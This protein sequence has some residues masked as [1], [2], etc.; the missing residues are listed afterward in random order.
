MTTINTALT[1]L[2]GID[3][4]LIL[5]PMGGASGGRLA[6][7]VS[8]A[9]GLGLVGASYGDPQW[10]ARELEMMREV[11]QP[12]GVGLVMFT[13]AKQFELLLLALEYRP[14][15]VA[16]SFGDVRPFVR[17]IH[18]ANAKVIV[19]VHD[20]DQA[21]EA[22][23]AGAD[24]LIVQ[25]AEAGGHSLRRASLPLFP[26]V[27]DAVGEHVVLIGA[28]GI[29]DG[30]GMAAALALGMDGVMMGTR[31]L[32][33]QE[34]LP[35]ERVKQRLLQAVASDTV[36]TRIFDQ[37]RGIDWPEGYSGRVIGND[38]SA[39]WVGEEQAF[40]ASAGQ[41]RLDYEAALAAD[42]VSIRAIWA[43]EVADLIKEVLPAQLIVESTLRG[44]A[45]SVERLRTP[46]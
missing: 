20:V 7:A 37:V 16:L 40:A 27:R 9:G 28:G 44:Y 15:V 33:S 43:G 17:P 31:F 35:S 23:D 46:R 14:A 41:L 8:R 2:L 22:L 21:L 12:W 1:S 26:A 30:R 25:G 24:A 39:S 32:A 38:F 10:M 18:Q 34:A 42:D 13:V 36:R 3:H 19:Q 5:A 4:P 45:A 6:A 11:Q 29:A